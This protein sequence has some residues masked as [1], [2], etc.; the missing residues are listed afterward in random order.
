MPFAVYVLGV[1]VFAISTSEFMLSGLVPAIATDLA[2]S[3][4]DAG[5][6]TSA[7]AIGMVVGGPP[8]AVLTMR[9]ERRRALAAFLVV[10]A[11]VHVVGAVSTDYAVLMVT[12]VLGALACAGFWA[13]AAVA[14][15]GMAG[16]NAKARAMSIVVGGTTLACV[17]GVPGGAFLGQHLGWRAAFWAVAVLSALSVVAVLA[18]LPPSAPEPVARIELKPLFSKPLVVAYALNALVQGA[19]FCTF[20]YLAPLVTEVAGLGAGWIPGT[21]VLFGIGSFIGITVGGR[22]ADA[23]PLTVLGAGMA[24]LALGWTLL[25]VTAGNA[26]V[27]VVLV[28]VQGLLAF[29]IAP[30]LT[31]RVFYLAGFAPTLA[32]G[33][34]TAAF[35]VGNTLGPWLGG[36]TIDA[37]LGF[38]SPVWVSALMMIIALGVFALGPKNSAG[39]VRRRVDPRRA[40]STQ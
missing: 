9:W 26:V 4:P 12:R 37:G 5:M 31:S 17:A 10:F 25:A 22:I 27:A 16:E 11:V 24:A 40:R 15:I 36:L 23:R 14:A 8:L 19:T 30:V 29:G 2:V 7:F 32:G 20:T 6:L 21:L 28:F 35:N 38:R 3:I 1:A 34:S 39:K 13:V 18:T 33:L